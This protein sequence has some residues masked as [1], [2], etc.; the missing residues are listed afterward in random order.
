MN[1][2]SSEPTDT[3]DVEASWAPREVPLEEAHGRH[4]LGPRTNKSSEHRNIITSRETFGTAV[5]AKVR[6]VYKGLFKQ[7]PAFL[8]ITEFSFRDKRT[9]IDE[10]LVT[11]TFSASDPQIQ[12]SSRPNRG[13]A[14][15]V[16]LYTPKAIFGR[17]RKEDEQLEYGG[18][19]E[20]SVA[21]AAPVSI[22]PG[23]HARKSVARTVERQLTITG[24][25]FSD[26]PDE[27]EPNQAIFRIQRDGAPRLPS[28]FF[29]GVIVERHQD[30]QA[31]VEIEV[32]KS[33]FAYPWS[34]KDAPLL[35]P[36]G[37]SKETA[38]G[39]EPFSFDDLTTEK[40]KELVPYLRE[41]EVS[42]N[43]QTRNA[44]R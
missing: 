17:I 16:R 24:Y 19:F 37:S 27:D 20:V 39:P 31:E 41:G 10:A 8:L 9:K 26:D 22:T 3:V 21:A 1:A 44:L 4:H 33:A 14:R 35:L 34:R 32:N 30:L 6:G 7:Q 38:L 42:R 40:W 13:C 15:A 2:T 25:E 11:F 18:T 12:D 23:I 29:F 43:M 28:S 5:Y 36:I